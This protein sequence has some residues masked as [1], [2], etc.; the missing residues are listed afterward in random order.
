ME[1]DRLR[2]IL[3]YLSLQKFPRFLFVFFQNL[4]ADDRILSDRE[5]AI[6]QRNVASLYRG[7]C[8]FISVQRFANCRHQG[9]FF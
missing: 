2:M 1:S 8:A 9:A 3:R 5:S 4:D 6:L 7:L